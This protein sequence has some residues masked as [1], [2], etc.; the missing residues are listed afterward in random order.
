M[1]LVGASETV[2]AAGGGYLSLAG[3]A[4]VPTVIGALFSGVLRSTGRPRSPMVATMAT[5]G[6]N[7]ALAYLFV[8]G[9]G[10]FP[11]LGAPGA[12]SP[13]SSPPP[14][15]PGSCAVQV[16]GSTGS[17][18]GSRPTGYA[19]GGASPGAGGAGAA[20]RITELFWTSGTFL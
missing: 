1:R 16:F 13:R 7:A 14:S 10:P 8:T 19:S 4:V 17:S 3:L 6:L 5:V 12:V 9:T 15:R 18:G 11:E 20:A 2:A